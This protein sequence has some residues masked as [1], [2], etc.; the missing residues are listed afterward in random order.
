MAT[1][2][3]INLPVKDLQKSMDFFTQLGFSFNPQFTDENGAC[4]VIGNNI[5][6]MLLAE[7][8]FKT[9]TNKPISSAKDSTEVIIAIDAAS[10]S[11]VDELVR[12]AQNAGGLIYRDPEDH[13]WIY[14]HSFADLDGHQWEVVYMD[15]SA[16]PKEG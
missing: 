7:P 10:R 13:G 8:F 11:E 3:F 5:F 4:M 14:G 16:L 2:I 6:A 9:F 12:K 15:M 1:Q